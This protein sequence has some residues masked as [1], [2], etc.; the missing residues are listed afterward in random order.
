MFSIERGMELIL[1]F[2][3]RNGPNASCATDRS[4]STT[5]QYRIVCFRFWIHH[6]PA[7]RQVLGTISTRPAERSR[8]FSNNNNTGITARNII[9]L[10]Q[11]AGAEGTRSRGEGRTSRRFFI[12]Y[13]SV[14]FFISF[15]F[16]TRVYSKI[17]EIIYTES[18][19]QHVFLFFHNIRPHHSGGVL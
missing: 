10:L 15:C 6:E 7:W 11:F 8:R 9:I 3:F 18:G 14:I 2:F 5:F 16:P 4:V 13:F 17:H 19:D 1:F 12:V